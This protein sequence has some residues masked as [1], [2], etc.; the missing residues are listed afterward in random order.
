[1]I[2][3]LPL[4]LGLGASLAALI[5]LCLW[6][7]GL[8][9]RNFSYVDLGWAANFA[10]LGLFYGLFAPGD[11][12]RR[13]LIATLY[14]VH[15]SRLALHLAG[16]IVGQPEEGRYVQLRQE[17]GAKGALD[18][19]FLVFFQFQALLNVF[20]TLPLLIASFNSAPA[21]LPLEIAGATLWLLAL[22]GEST[23]D[24]QLK[25]FIRNPANKG[26]VCDVGLWRYSRHPNYFC[27]WLIWIGYALFALA[28]PYGW[29]ALLMPALML[30][31]LLNVT[32]VKPTEEQSLRSKGDKYRDYQARTSRFVPMPPR[33]T[34]GST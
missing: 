22:L 17:W 2:D 5:M 6:L 18:L 32:G 7:L 20:L 30:H 16:R 13:I 11:P 26:E 9:R 21:P 8:K 25:S 27:E 1:M 15:G 34:G 24:A 14:V 4:L 19:K 31:L 28:S 10:V 3:S 33:K 23:A 29:I 12:V